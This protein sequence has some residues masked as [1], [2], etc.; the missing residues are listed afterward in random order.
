MK[1][2]VLIPACSKT[3]GL[4]PFHVVGAKYVEAVTQGAGC[5]PLLLPPVGDAIEIDELL[6]SADG[7]MLT[8]SASN[9][10]PSHFGQEVANPALPLDP[11]RDATTLPLVRRAIALGVPL[12]AICRGFQ[13]M[14]V[15]LGGSLH[16][17]VHALPGMRDHREDKH[18]P[19]DVQYGPAHSLRV[20]PGGALALALG[21][22]ADIVVN[23]VHGQGVD[24][25]AAGLVVEATAEDG[26]IES[27]SVAGSRGFALGVQWHPEWK[28]RENPLSMKIFAAFGSACRER[29]SL[30]CALRERE[31]MT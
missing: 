27:F 25:L 14:N 9:V 31:P 19:L 18:A 24:R 23:S 5:L 15:A 4:H 13:E 10:H 29:A 16:Q 12:L 22:G 26:L 7:V 8:G 21:S 28:V 3:I 30:R 20:V 11:A 17:A 2:V 6:A 1:P